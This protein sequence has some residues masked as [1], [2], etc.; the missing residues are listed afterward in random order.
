MQTTAQTAD[1]TIMALAHRT[2][3]IYGVQFHPESVL[4]EYGYRLLAN[5]LTL[6]G[7]QYHIDNELQNAELPAKTVAADLPAR[8][9]TF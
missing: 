4:T 3:P 2:R 5:F 9:V 1:G 6:A 7:I 8:P